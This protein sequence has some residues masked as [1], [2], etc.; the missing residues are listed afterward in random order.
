MLGEMYRPKGLALETAQTVLETKEVYA[1]NVA[2]GCSNNCLYPCFN[3]VR[4]FRRRHEASEVRLPKESPGLLVYRQISKMWPATIPALL[5]DPDDIGVFLSFL[6]DPFLKIVAKK[7]RALIRVLLDNHTIGNH[8]KVATLSKLQCSYIRDVLDGMTI[9]SLDDDF[10]HKWEPNTVPP[11]ARLRQLEASKDEQNYVWV[12]MEPY[13][14]SE[15]YKQDFE[16]L[17]EQLKFVDLI[18]FGKW[19]YNERARTEQARTEYAEHV[20]TLTKFGLKHRIRTYV[21]SDTLKFIGRE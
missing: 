17:L 19:N 6:T 21:K 9:V 13:P 1:V 18:V 8:V 3:Q 14:P 12:S 20:K 10:W 15:I 5:C 2:D 11:Y 16:A 7:T 4:F